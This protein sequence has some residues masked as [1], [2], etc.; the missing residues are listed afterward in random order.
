M[1]PSKVKSVT[2]DEDIM[3]VYKYKDHYRNLLS[4]PPRIPDAVR[5]SRTDAGKRLVNGKIHYKPTKSETKIEYHIARF[6]IGLP[7]PTKNNLINV[8]NIERI[9]NDTKWSKKGIYTLEYMVDSMK[10]VLH[11]YKEDIL[12]VWPSK[13]AKYLGFGYTAFKRGSYWA[14]SA[15]DDKKKVP[16]AVYVQIVDLR[17]LVQEKVVLHGATHMDGKVHYSASVPK[18]F[19]DNKD[20]HLENK[21]TFTI[22]VVP[23]G[24]RIVLNDITDVPNDLKPYEQ[25]L[26]A[27]SF[28]HNTI[29]GFKLREIYDYIGPVRQ[30]MPQVY[31]NKEKMEKFKTITVT[32]YFLGLRELE[33]GH[34]AT[35][36]ATIPID[37]NMVL[38]KPSDFLPKLNVKSTEFDYSVVYDKNVQRFIIKCGDEFF[39]KLSKP[40]GSVLGFDNEQVPYMTFLPSTETT[41]Q[42]F[43]VMNRA[44]TTLYVYTNIVDDVFVGNVKAPLLLTCPYKQDTLNDVVQV[45]FFRPTYAKLNRSQFQQIDVAIHDE[46]GSLVP[47]LYGKTVLTLHFRKQ[48]NLM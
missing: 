39:I 17:N 16:S 22:D 45:E 9:V 23:E 42:Y 33:F 47:F 48:M 20:A 8:K 12:V 35:P 27:Y 13:L 37:S 34:E 11:C 43:P 38:K 10:F 31:N 40:L 21:P 3:Y 24:G 5:L 18:K 15:F 6:E 46:A 36:L 25:K 32:F 4:T 29:G 7:P 28:D 30:R 44:I 2:E 41:A 19:A 1:Y 14:W 26:F